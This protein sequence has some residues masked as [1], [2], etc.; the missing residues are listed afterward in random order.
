MFTNVDYL[1]YQAT[2]L[3]IQ[4]KA[5]HLSTCGGLIITYNLL[6]NNQVHSFQIN[7]NY[8]CE[9]PTWTNVR[10][11]WTCLLHSTICRKDLVYMWPIFWWNIWCYCCSKSCIVWLEAASS[12]FHNLFCDFLIDL[13]FTPSRED[14]DLWMSKSVKY[15][16]YDYNAT[17]LYDIIIA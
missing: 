12:L 7:V 8:S 9:E 13:G 4:I 10:G 1:W 14:Q 3:Y 15:D 16:V 6:I 2:R 11:H 17:H 5:S